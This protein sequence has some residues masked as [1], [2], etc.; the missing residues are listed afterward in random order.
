MAIGRLVF[1][2]SRD[3]DGIVSAAL[4]VRCLRDLKLMLVDYEDISRLI[5]EIRTATEKGFGEVYVADLALAEFYAEAVL[6]AAAEAI[7][8]GISIMWFDHHRPPAELVEE[9]SRHGIIMRLDQSRC[10]GE[11]VS[12]A[13]CG[14]SENVLA[15]L[16][17]DTDFL[18][19]SHPLS[20]PLAELVTYYYH[21]GEEWRL[22]RLAE[23]MAQGVIWDE[24]VE[25]DWR[26]A[27]EAIEE[28][29]GRMLSRVVLRNPK[30]YRIAGSYANTLIPTHT[31]PLLLVEKMDADLGLVLYETGEFIIAKRRGVTL[32]CGALAR[33]V[34]GGGHPHMAGGWFKD[35][36]SLEGKLRKLLSMMADV[37]KSP[38]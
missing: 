37:I 2:H 16:A 10:S 31:G 19:F 9:A 24:T 38:S 26:N 14:D 20:R 28:E 11:I 4:M 8:E 23:R 18:I 22:I 25:E 32:D 15:R 35:G 36:G 5:E 30:G 17:H 13:L 1:S 3:L 27:R 6:K 34:G 7:K 12:E 29:E 33:G 21:R